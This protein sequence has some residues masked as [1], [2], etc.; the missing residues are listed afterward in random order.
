MRYDYRT[1]VSL[2]VAATGLLIGAERHCV[3]SNEVVKG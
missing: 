2:L 3:H 1:R